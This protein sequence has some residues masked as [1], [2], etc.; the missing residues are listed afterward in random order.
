MVQNTNASSL[1]SKTHQCYKFLQLHTNYIDTSCQF[2]NTCFL[3][4]AREASAYHIISNCFS[5]GGLYLYGHLAWV[6]ESADNRLVVHEAPYAICMYRSNNPNSYII[7][8]TKICKWYI[9]IKPSWQSDQFQIGIPTNAYQISLFCIFN[10][11]TTGFSVP[12][13]QTFKIC[14]ESY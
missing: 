5:F 1:K 7:Y 11:E 10:S 6:P 12:I 2:L 4:P 8:T 9:K 14:F 13:F 3:Y